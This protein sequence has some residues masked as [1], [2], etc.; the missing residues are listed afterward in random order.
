MRMKLLRVTFDRADLDDRVRLASYFDFNSSSAQK[1][2]GLDRAYSI[3]K[4]ADRSCLL[5]ASRQPVKQRD[6]SFKH[7]LVFTDCRT[8][9][10][11]ES[12]LIRNICEM[13]ET[14]HPHVFVAE[15]E[16]LARHLGSCAPIL[17][18]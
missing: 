4:Y 10:W 13:I 18:Q 5:L 17:C 16:E 14:H 15:Q 12:D 6:G 8:D 7:A 3:S 9:R 11:R 2:L 1:I